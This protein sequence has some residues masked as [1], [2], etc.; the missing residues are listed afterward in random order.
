M[1]KIEEVKQKIYLNYD[2]KK[3]IENLCFL[4]EEKI[5]SLE[6]QLKSEMKLN[7]SLNEQ[8]KELKIYENFVPYI[9]DNKEGEVIS[10]ENI[11]N[12]LSELINKN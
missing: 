4:F 6:N 2:N 5:T 3:L 9:I 1:T 12:W 10:E 8:N 11:H 7:N